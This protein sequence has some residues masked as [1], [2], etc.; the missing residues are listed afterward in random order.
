MGMPTLGAYVVLATIGA[1]ALQ[2]LG[3]SL[4][5]AHLFIFYFACLSAI[6]PPVALAA[7]VAAGIANANPFKVGFT[8][9]RMGIIKFI[10]PFMFVY[11]PGMM[12]QGDMLP[13][14]MDMFEMVLLLIPV[15]VLTMGGYWLDRLTWTEKVLFAI[16][17]LAVFTTKTIEYSYLLAV[18]SEA[19]AIFLHLKR[20]KYNAAWRLRTAV[21]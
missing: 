14:L 21:V 5:G 6:T 12:I 18:V 9:V 4:L 13:I 3:A 11:R 17:I 20:T 15:S 1:P 16:S 8:A 19:V 10:I 2:Q 7:F